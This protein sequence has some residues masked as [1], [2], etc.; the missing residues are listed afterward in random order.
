[1]LSCA[2]TPESFAPFVVPTV[3]CAPLVL[4]RAK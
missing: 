3:A 2:L 1:M 4:L